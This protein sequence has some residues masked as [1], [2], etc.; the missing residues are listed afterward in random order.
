[1]SQPSAAAALPP[2]AARSNRARPIDRRSGLSRREFVHEYHLARKPVILSG[3]I[4]EWPARTLWTPQFFRERYGDQPVTAGR[5]FDK[6]V[7]TTMRAYLDLMADYA[8][9]KVQEPPNRPPLYL[10]GWYFRRPC[11]ELGQHYSLPPIFGPDWFSRF[12]PD[13]YDPKGTALLIGPKGTF[14]KLHYDLLSTH[15]WNAQLIGRKRWV[16]ADP[17]HIAA[18][19]LDTRNSGGY[20]PGTDLDAPDL[21]RYPQLGEI[22]YL[23]GIVQPGEVIFFPERWLHQVTALD[24]SISLTHNYMSANNCVPV[25]TKMLRAR[26]GGKNL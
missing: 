25:V 9:G 26:L 4:D 12:F 17:K 15:S 5:C 16:L 14:T 22:E 20:V 24:E 1:M 18:V 2:S 7:K 13:K 8:S 3:L 19:Y 10:E 6:S 23:E 11:P 21:A